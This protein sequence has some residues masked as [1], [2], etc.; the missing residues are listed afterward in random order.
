MSFWD[1]CNSDSESRKKIFAL[2]SRNSSPDRLFSSRYDNVISAVRDRRYSSL[3]F[4]DV[5]R[6]SF[7]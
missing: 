4:F 3:S 1:V 5:S 2:R 7:N 6:L